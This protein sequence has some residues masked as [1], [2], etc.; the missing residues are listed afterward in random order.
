MKVLETLW[1]NHETVV[2]PNGFLTNFIAL[3]LQFDTKQRCFSFQLEQDLEVNNAKPGIVHVYDY[4]DTG[5]KI[6]K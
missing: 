2:Q 1:K 4:Y 3:Y 6:E 5:N